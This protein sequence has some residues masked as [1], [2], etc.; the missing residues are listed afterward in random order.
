VS[1]R[2]HQLFSPSDLEAVAEAARVAE[3][4]TSAE[5]VPY[6]VE[7]SDT[8]DG[9]LWKGAAAGAVLGGLAAGLLHLAAGYWGGNP[10]LWTSLPTAAGALVGFM[11][12]WLLP[13]LRRALID[14]ET[15]Q[16]RVLRRAQGAFLEEQVFLTRERTGILLFVSLFE[17]RVVVLGDAGINAKVVPETWDAIAEEVARGIR[18]GRAAEAICRALGECAELLE[19]HGLARPQDD[20]N[21]LSD[22]P[23]LRDR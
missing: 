2:L 9:P 8:Y 22:E 23:R 4:R 16:S 6:V 15:L 11:L 12:V 7:Q 5:L 20:R 3:R 10:L 13:A 19:R 17:R 18:R 1:V 14:S 21:E